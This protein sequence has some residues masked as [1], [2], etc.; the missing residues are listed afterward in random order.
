MDD[1]F[2]WRSDLAHDYPLMILAPK[3]RPEQNHL[4]RALPTEARARLFPILELVPMALGHVLYESGDIQDHVYFPIDSII[5][6]MFVTENGASA[7][8]AMLGNEGMVGV[9]LISDNKAAPNRA[10]VQSSGVAYRLNGPLFKR[11]FSRAGALQQLMLRYTQTLLTQMAQTAVCNR[12]HAADQQL[13][14]LLLMSLDRLSS[15]HL[16]MTHELIANMLGVRRETVTEAAVKLQSAGAIRYGRGSIEVLD[17]QKLER[18]SCECYGVVTTE[19][20]RQLP[21]RLAAELQAGTDAE[22]PPGTDHTEVINRLIAQLRA[23][24]RDLEA[25]PGSAAAVS[26]IRVLDHSEQVEAVVKESA[27]ELAAV[28]SGLKKDLAGRTSQATI[29]VT[30]QKNELVEAKVEEAAE[31]LTKVNL[32]LKA[33]VK[34]RVVLEHELVDV[35]QQEK[36]SRHAALHDPLTSLPN[37]G[38]FNDR[39]EQ[40]VTQARRNGHALAVMLIELR[41]SEGTGSAPGDGWNDEVLLA[42][43]TQLENMKREDDTLTR[44]GDREFLYLRT[45]LKSDRD[46]TAIADEII[47]TL[48]KLSSTSGGVVAA[49]SP[50]SPCIGIAVFPRDGETAEALVSRADEA[51]H[52]A[53][54]NSRGH[55]FAR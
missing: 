18:A 38:L 1:T 46:A 54:E 48:G 33:E 3:H 36:A 28:N 16:K 32:A 41:N 8:I 34:E 40:S 24:P 44:H 51:R 26:L 37:K 23:S 11:E 9:T 14:R 52:H 17:R 49:K 35:K 5:S 21:D 22:I 12:H 47:R 43:V 6:L 19:L 53:K 15:N 4:L 27:D 30:L 45:E 25:I 2:A 31:D 13:C 50:F 10:V 55:S 29:A 20:K 39:L 42:T 7:E